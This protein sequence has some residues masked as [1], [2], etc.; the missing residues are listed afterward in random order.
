MD[1][2]INIDLLWLSWLF[3]SRLELDMEEVL[4]M[5]GGVGGTSWE[6]LLVRPEWCNK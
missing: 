5:G 4:G 1:K 6:L 2:K 3:L